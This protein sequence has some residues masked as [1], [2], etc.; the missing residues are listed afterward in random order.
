MVNQQTCLD[1]GGTQDITRRCLVSS[2]WSHWGQ[3]AGCSSPC[4]KP[5]RL[6][7]VQHQSIMANHTKELAAQRCPVFP[8]PS[9]EQNLIFP[10]IE[11]LISWLAGVGSGLLDADNF[12]TCWF[13]YTPE[14]HVPIRC[15]WSLMQPLLTISL[16]GCGCSC[17]CYSK[18]W[19]TTAK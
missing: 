11:C 4:C 6:S 12:H 7:A 14:L 16:F 10:H 2:A 3:D 13:A 19:A 17:F 8:N 15:P 5:I 18:L 9:E 1:S